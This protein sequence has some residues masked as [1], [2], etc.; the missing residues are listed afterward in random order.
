MADADIDLVAEQALLGGLERWLADPEVD[1]VMVNGGRDVWIDRRGT[2]TKVGSIR[3]STLL[4]AVER[5]LSP[6]GRRVDRSQPMVDARLADGS[7]LCV[8]IEPVAVDGP[9]VAIRRFAPR[10]IP[11]HQFAD[12]STTAVLHEAIAQRCN[13]VVSG[14]TSSG[15]TT[16]LAALAAHIERTSRLVVLEDVAELRLEHPHVVR[17]ETRDATPD[18][19]G[20]LGLDALLR[21]ALRLRPDRMVVGE[22]RGTEA[23]HLLHALN[24]GHDGSMSTVHA[25]SAL[26]ALARLASL[27]LQSAPNWP[28]AAVREHVA[29]AIDIIVHV[30]RG[31]DGRRQVVEIAEVCPPDVDHGAVLATRTV[32]SDRPDAAITR[33][34]RTVRP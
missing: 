13:I 3:T 5:L 29:R 26:D 16:L 12:T 23:V 7:R 22:I 17:L 9:C 1:E 33:R 11:L 6:T 14:A 15:K 21:T 31:H 28:L 18:G 19:V 25:N 30:E 4:A 27:V 2:L 8:A 10:Q 34:R 32:S 20:A 24:T